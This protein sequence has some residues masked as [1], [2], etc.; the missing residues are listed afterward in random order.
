MLM[1]GDREPF[2]DENAFGEFIPV[3]AGA[4]TISASPTAA[5]AAKALRDR[6]SAWATE[7]GFV[8]V[9]SRIVAQID[10]V[11]VDVPLYSITPGTA[12]VHARPLSK[13][14]G[15]LVVEPSTFRHR[16]FRFLHRQRRSTGDAAF[17]AAF[18]VEASDP[19]LAAR[20]LDDR[21]RAAIRACS[22]WCRARFQNDA[23]DVFLDAHVLNGEGLFAGMM[24]AVAM[25][26]ASADRTAY[27]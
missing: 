11:D 22:I 3:I 1:I 23:I 25:A 19:A 6:A 4:S 24:V 17:D 20:L 8:V 10:A 2:G 26:R 12:V 13:V 21:T 27:R 14:G 5:R 9:D 7:R 16:A 18:H 15:T